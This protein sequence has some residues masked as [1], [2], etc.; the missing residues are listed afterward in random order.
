MSRLSG[1]SFLVER[2]WERGLPW[3]HVTRGRILLP[4]HCRQRPRPRT[5]SLWHRYARFPPLS[6]AYPRRDWSGRSAG[7][8][9]DQRPEIIPM[10]AMRKKASFLQG[11]G[12]GS[13]GIFE[14]NEYMFFIFI[15]FS[16]SRSI[17][18]FWYFPLPLPAITFLMVRPLLA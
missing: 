12:R 6:L 7:S 14:L 9:P 4:T 5:K 2:P 1:P 15:Q 3:V 8:F 13:W 17:F 11:R 16:L 10:A 18:R